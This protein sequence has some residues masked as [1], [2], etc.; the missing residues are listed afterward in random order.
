MLCNSCECVYINGIKCHE[1]GCPEAWRDHKHECK[2]CGIEFKPED[3]YRE[4]CSDS[5]YCD[6]WGLPSDELTECVK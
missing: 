1:H 2:N 5:C 6:Y 3:Q 4:C